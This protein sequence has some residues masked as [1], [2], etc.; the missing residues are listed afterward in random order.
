[1]EIIISNSSSVPIYEQIKEQIKTKILN[2]ELQSGECLPSIRSLAKD[3]KCSVITTKNAYE[4][5]QKEGYVTTIPAKGFYVAHIS[6]ELLREE[7]LQKIENLLDTSI[8]LAKANKISKK[9]LLEIIEILY[10]EDE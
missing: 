5:L 1:M 2:G 10:E 4:E 7:Q 6:Q 8:L 3:L 9:K